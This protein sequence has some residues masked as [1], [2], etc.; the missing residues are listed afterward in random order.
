MRTTTQG[1]VLAFLGVV[2]IRLAAGGNYLSFVTSW[3]QW[4][5]IIS[6]VLLIIVGAGP[7]LGF[8]EPRHEAH[9]TTEERTEH[10]VPAVT[11]LLL[12]PGLIVF[13]VSP[14]A[15]GA[16]L[17][18]RRVDDTPAAS[19]TSTFSALPAGDPVE[20]ELE[21]FIWR[22]QVDDGITLVGRSVRVSGFVTH[23]KDD[24]WYV[25]RMSIGCCAA[26]AVV[27]RVRVDNPVS[28]KRDSWVQVTGTW[29]DGS[30]TDRREV[31]HIL[32]S[33]VVA[34]SAP[35]QTYQ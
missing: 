19:P 31:P 23:D 22:A 27:I 1:L 16:Y 26:D 14:P 33:D 8:P 21:E 34:V 28:P 35:R 29:A 9:G 10:G 7:A 11:W 24:N 18:E 3:M 4:P 13:T 2:L 17:A 20:L 6:G 25:T 30:G 15:L 5:I 12:L 32:A